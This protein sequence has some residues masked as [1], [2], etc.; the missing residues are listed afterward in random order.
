MG[1][2]A[3]EAPSHADRCRIDD[4]IAQVQILLNGTG[5]AD[6][7]KCFHA[8]AG[9]L[10]YGKGDAGAAHAGGHD[11]DR[12]VFHPGEPCGVIPVRGDE[13][14]ISIQRF[15]KAFHAARVAGEKGVFRAADHI[16]GKPRVVHDVC[17][18]GVIFHMVL[19]S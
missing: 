12:R 13:E 17:G 2:Y 9:Q 11:K 14:G 19:L 10:L 8:E 6:A 3:R 15:G 4:Y 1:A 16:G 5:R 7:D 18:A